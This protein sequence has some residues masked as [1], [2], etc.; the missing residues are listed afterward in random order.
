[1]SNRLIRAEFESRLATWAAAKVP[2][3][4][5]AYQ[6][7]TFTPPTARH[8]RAFLLPA[9]TD[10]R[11]L[12]GLHRL[13]LGVWQVSLFM[14]IGTGAG[15][16]ELLVDEICDLYPKSMSV[17]LPTSEIILTLSRPMSAAPPIN[18]PAYYIVPISCS[19]SASN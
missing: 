12:D 7:K 8:V 10:S 5:V 4:P 18:D 1:M 13:Y 9:Q 6:N 3:I 19:Y 2:P 15:A 11:D 14:P 16:A 17:L